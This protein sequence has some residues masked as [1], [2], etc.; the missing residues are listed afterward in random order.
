[1]ERLEGRETAD[2]TFTHSSIKSL[3]KHKLQQNK[4]WLKWFFS[5]GYQESN[6]TVDQ[7]HREA[8]VSPS[9]DRIKT[10]MKAASE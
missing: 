9:L 6:Q 8:V 10:E 5:L 7:V 4:L 1:M 3:R 2:P